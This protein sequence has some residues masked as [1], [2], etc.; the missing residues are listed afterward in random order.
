MAA[1]ESGPSQDVSEGA[2]SLLKLEPIANPGSS[3]DF[4]NIVIG[5]TEDG[6]PVTIGQLDTSAGGTVVIVSNDQRL[7]SD[8]ARTSGRP[9]RST[10][11]RKSR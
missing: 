5:N 4:L 6:G 10:R 8:R 7:V 1:T 3:L 2:N 9:V 11:R